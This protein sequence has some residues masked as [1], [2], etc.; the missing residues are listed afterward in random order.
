[1]CGSGGFFKHCGEHGPHA[2][3]L[4]YPHLLHRRDREVLR[5]DPRLLRPGQVG[6]GPALQVSLPRAIHSTPGT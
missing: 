4:H 5:A 2:V 1:M 3:V 6:P